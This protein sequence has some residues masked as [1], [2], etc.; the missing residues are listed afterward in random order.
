MAT[1]LPGSRQVALD[2]RNLDTLRSQ[3]AKD[4]QAALRSAAQQFEAV[5]MS[6]L[7]KS[8][9]DTVPQ[10]GLMG[11]GNESATY[12]SMLDQQ[13]AQTL[14][15]SG[16]G[17]GLA[18]MLVKQLSRNLQASVSRQDR[19]EKMN[20]MTQTAI[21]G[22]ELPKQFIGNLMGEARVAAQRTGIPAE[23]MLG[24]AALESGW[25][26][27]EIVGR[28]GAR[29]FNLF[30]IKATSAW[31]GR[32]VESMTTEYIDG[33]PEKRVERF[34]AYDSYAQ[35][36]EDYA[37][38]ISQSPRYAS[39]VAQAA[40]TG[41]VATFAQGLQQGGYATDPR[42]AEKLSRVINQT[43]ALSRLV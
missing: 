7:L 29:S 1:V 18:D 33:K 35:A 4:P 43:I 20:Q 13:L 14:S 40:R 8:M 17:T 28:D 34:R 22:S 12:T 11:A 19:A 32:V 6:M 24:Q 42:Y 3:A 27:A 30:G 15:T 9:R 41:S 36:F 2:S 16:K 31:K 38:L 39:S 25:G 23:F 37:Q 5:F 21:S 26:K 10:S